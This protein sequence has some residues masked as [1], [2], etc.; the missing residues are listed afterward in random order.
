L[1]NNLKIKEKEING[2]LA[3]DENSQNALKISLN[4]TFLILRVLKMR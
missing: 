2:Q 4:K 1:K 3:K